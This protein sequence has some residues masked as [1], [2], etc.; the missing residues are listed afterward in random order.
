MRVSDAC[1]FATS[2]SLEIAAELIGRHV[3]P[4]REQGL[5]SLRRAESVVNPY[6]LISRVSEP[7]RTKAIVNTVP[8]FLRPNSL[9]QNSRSIAQVD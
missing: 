7:S 6:C 5:L 2:A 9:P 3:R 8:D 4:V 1:K